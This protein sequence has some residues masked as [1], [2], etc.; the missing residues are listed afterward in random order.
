MGDRQADGFNRPLPTKF[1][2][3]EWGIMQDFSRSAGSVDIRDDPL[4]A[5][6]GARAFRNFKDTV[7]RLG[8]FGVR[9]KRTVHFPFDQRPK[10]LD[11][12]VA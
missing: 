8:H 4:P 12:F 11:D 5:I 7:C 6:H 10:V 2:V 9:M 3:H 1:D